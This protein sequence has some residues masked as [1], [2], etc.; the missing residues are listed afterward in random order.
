VFRQKVGVD[1]QMTG[2]DAV[3]DR[4]TVTFDTASKTILLGTTLPRVITSPDEKPSPVGIAE[5][6]L[7][8]Q[9]A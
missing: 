5:N 8:F 1:L 4:T 6:T 3:D 7:F 2:V 9:Y